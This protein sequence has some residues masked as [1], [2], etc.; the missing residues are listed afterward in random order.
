MDGYEATRA[1]RARGYPGL[2]LGVT[3]NALEADKR[4]FI[5]AGVNQVVPKPVKPEDIVSLVLQWYGPLARTSTA[6]R[7]PV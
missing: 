5:T 4:A 1:L 3:G 6:P 7:V 2:I